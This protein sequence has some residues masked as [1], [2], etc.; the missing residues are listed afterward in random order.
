[1]TDPELGDHI[2]QPFRTIEEQLSSTVDFVRS[3]M[4]RSRSVVVFTHTI[5]RAAM[6]AWLE[7]QVDGFAEAV[8]RGSA[9]VVPCSEVHLAD[10][11]FDPERTMGGFASAATAAEAAGLNGIL[12]VVDMAWALRQLPGT[13][14]LLQYEAAANAV[15]ADR[16]MA[17]VCQYDR[18]L[19]GAS[20][21]RRACAAHPLTP[22]QSELRFDRTHHGLRVWGTVD[23]TN[24][25]AFAGLLRS[26][27]DVRA[28]VTVDAAGLYAADVSAACLIADCA[29]ARPGRRTVVTAGLS[30]GR[31]LT[32]I[33]AE[34]LTGL[35]VQA[36]PAPTS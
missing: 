1:M 8:T 12:V 13:E 2:C 20:V 25:D 24:L 10:G 29:T 15:F 11:R 35:T 14:R 26:L 27:A 5:E 9:D 31:F 19:F 7:S 33:G 3:G 4:A 18:R 21:P 23:D 17:A 28:D 30:L 32:L 34:K 22:D 6:S 36:E 16:R